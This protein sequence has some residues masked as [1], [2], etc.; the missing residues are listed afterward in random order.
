MQD[1]A[2]INNE[3]ILLRK[4]LKSIMN[5]TKLNLA[6][7]IKK[8]KN[9]KNVNQQS[10]ERKQNELE[11]FK[12][13]KVSDVILRN[14]L[15]SEKLQKTLTD[16]GSTEND[17]VLARKI[18][19]DSF[20]VDSNGKNYVASINP[21]DSMSSEEEKPKIFLRPKNRK[22]SMD[23]ARNHQLQ[24]KTKQNQLKTKQE[25]S[26]KIISTNVNQSASIKTEE[27]EPIHP[28]WQAKAKMREKLK[29]N[30]FQGKKIKFDE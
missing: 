13:L 24:Y 7:K 8:L 4:S 28:S 11:C 16:S 26:K 30:E 2:K 5:Q 9:A 1:I 25:K 20:F 22:V 6:K 3:V 27:T 17:R 23:K 15:F 29:I 18:N 12:R 10:V 19:K 14:G 21:D